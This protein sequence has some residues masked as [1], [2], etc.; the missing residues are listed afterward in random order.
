MRHG[1]ALRQALGRLAS[2]RRLQQIRHHLR[3]SLKDQCEGSLTSQIRMRTIHPR[4]HAFLR[5]EKLRQDCQA[6]RN[7]NQMRLHGNRS[8]ALVQPGDTHLGELCKIRERRS[9][10]RGDPAGIEPPGLGIVKFGE[11]MRADR[12][13]GGSNSHSALVLARMSFENPSEAGLERRRF[14]RPRNNISEGVQIVPN[15]GRFVRCKQDDAYIHASKLLEDF[16]SRHRWHMDI[17]Q[18]ETGRA[19]RRSA[20]GFFRGFDRLHVEAFFLEQFRKKL[21]AFRSCLYQHGR[22]HRFPLLIGINLDY[23]MFLLPLH[24]LSLE[25]VFLDGVCDTTARDQ[26]RCAGQYSASTRAPS[27]PYT[28]ADR[29]FRLSSL[30]LIP[31]T[32]SA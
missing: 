18:N 9:E 28:G 3:F 17:E 8:R 5:R 21:P 11:H 6:P 13:R 32:P 16:E 10:K 30:D 14:D 23:T 4:E 27:M 19:F 31:A 15:R 20:E 12:M 2:E 1:A 7:R 29:T 25:A 24:R 26:T 22:F